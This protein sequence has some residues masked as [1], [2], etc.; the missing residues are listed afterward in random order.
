[1]TSRCTWCVVVLR[2]LVLLACGG[3]PVCSSRIELKENGY[4]GIVV[5]LSAR[6]QGNVAGRQLI[7]P[8]EAL[9]RN[10]SISLFQSSRNRAYLEEVIVLVPKSWGPKETWARAPTP[11][12]S[13]TGWQLHRDADVRLE[14]QGSPFGDNPFTVQ[15][16][17]CGLQAKRLVLSAGFLRLVD[18]GGPKAAM[19][20]PPERVFVREWAHLRYGVFN[21]AGYPGDPLY[22]A[23]TARTGSSDPTD[24]VLTTCTDTPLDLDWKTTSGQQCVAHVDPLTGRPDGDDCHAVPN[25]TQENVFSSIMALQTLPNVN[26]FCDGDEHLHNDEAPSKQNVMC[27]YRSTWDVIS[28]HAD[29]HLRNQAGERLL[30]R[31]RFHYVQEAPLRV[32][33]VVQVSA[34]SALKDRRSFVIRA[35]DKFARVDA[36]E[37]SRLGLAAFGQVEAAVK[38]PLTLMNSSSVRSKLGQRVPV[39]GTK[40]NSSVEE[41]ISKALQMLKEDRELPYPTVNGSAAA[42]GVILLLS[43]GD[44]A[45]DVAERLQE[46][47]VASQVRLQS[48]VYPQSEHPEPH[49]DALVEHTGGRT[50]HVH[51]AAV[52]DQLQG[53]VATQAELYEAFYSLLLRGYSWD[54]TDNY[55]MV[56]KR[57]FGE[58]EQESGAP[59]TLSFDVDPGLA[60]QLLVVVV[61]YDFSNIALPSITQEGIHLKAPNGNPGYNA[62]DLSVFNFDYAFWSYSFKIAEPVVGMWELHAE[63]TKKT[64]QPVIGIVYAKP[65]VKEVPILLDVWISGRSSAVNSSEKFIIYAELKKGSHPVAKALVTAFVRR[66]DTDIVSRVHLIDNGAGDPDLTENDGVYCRYFTDFTGTGRYDLT[67]VANDNDVSAVIIGASDG[68]FESRF[69]EGAEYPSCCGS[70]VS[71]SYSQKTN[72]FTRTDHY[73]SFFVTTEK[74]S[75]DVLPPSRITDLRVVSTDNLRMAV[76]FNWTAPGD[77]FDEGQAS[78]YEL[79]SFKDKL[80]A[81]QRF[82]SHGQQVS[83][84]D[85]DGPFYEPPRPFGTT[86]TATVRLK[87]NQSPLYFAIRAVDDEGNAG[88]VSNVVEV[89][90]IP[91]PTT[92]STSTQPSSSWGSGG[93]AGTQEHSSGTRSSRDKLNA[94]QLALIIAVPLAVLLVGIIVII[95]LMARRRKAP[96]PKKSAENGNAQQPPPL[97][98]KIPRD[99]LPPQ[100]TPIADEDSKQTPPG[101]LDSSIS[102][103]NSWPASVLLDHYNKV[104]QAK[105]RHEPPPIMMVED[106]VSL[107]SSTPS[108]Y[109]KSDYGGVTAPR[110]KHRGPSQETVAPSYNAVYSSSQHSLDKTG[111]GVTRN[112][113]QV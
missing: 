28:N 85:V 42:G 23:Y 51:E 52:A 18:E 30:G 47:L 67:V 24:V 31:T 5:A 97:P 100:V 111:G 44:M 84:W 9:L 112:I 21:E 49:L 88:P 68:D 26:Q 113:T 92:T 37:D 99:D 107:N 69:P 8:L 63:P 3:G 101:R 66:P 16:A 83:Q 43:S 64:A 94:A 72:R 20:G 109:S 59:L 25:R 14:P 81:R 11:S 7:P 40:F 56:E 71:D 104:Q 19:Y 1:M 35:L 75:K 102:P 91:P 60:R 93:T 108:L 54:E 61:G 65:A 33:I 13:R 96:P 106:G 6:L 46:S 38:V 105:Q 80:N 48:I 73:G 10:A 27:G 41:G 55:V 29:F 86:Q 50:W 103:V 98:A 22:P 95:L 4:T 15:H 78:R 12:V 76:T 36:P 79:K 45:A 53:S 89:V 90:V 32:V 39:P 58:A 70:R 2:L 110:P 82:S 62:N 77:D 74:A 34:A 17:G 87:S 57:E